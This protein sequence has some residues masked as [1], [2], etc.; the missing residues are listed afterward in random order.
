MESFGT[1]GPMT[2]SRARTSGVSGKVMWSK[3]YD[4]V[5]WLSNMCKMVA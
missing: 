3:A 5:S 4:C 1:G 2:R